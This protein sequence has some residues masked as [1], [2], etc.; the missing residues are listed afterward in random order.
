VACGT[1]QQLGY[2]L[3]AANLWG[4]SLD[5]A[6]EA[7]RH[8]FSANELFNQKWLCCSYSPP[9]FLGRRQK[10]TEKNSSTNSFVLAFLLCLNVKKKHR[11]CR[12]YYKSLPCK[13]TFRAEI[14]VDSFFTPP[15]G[16]GQLFES[17]LELRKDSNLQLKAS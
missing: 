1:F 4:R 17:E 2:V 16:G 12:K 15:P 8:Q 14:V 6:L 9:L 11:K 13:I 7:S 5:T 10:K 3:R